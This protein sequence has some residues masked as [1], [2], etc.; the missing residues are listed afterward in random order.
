[1]RK[2]ELQ[3]EMDAFEPQRFDDR[4]GQSLDPVKVREGRAKEHEKL[5]QR[6]VY[7]PVLRTTGSLSAPSGWTLRRART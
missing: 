2:D 5:I 1:M 7:E 4:T 3:E 6:G